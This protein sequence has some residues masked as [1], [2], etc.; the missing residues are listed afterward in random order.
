MYQYQYGGKKGLT[1]QLTEAS[2]LV[3]VRTKEPTN[4]K[5]LTLSE[6][7]K[8]LLPKM[9]PVV[10]FPEA[11]VTVF[12]CIDKASR[13][14][15]GGM[16]LRNQVRK[17]FNQEASIHFAGRVLKDAKSGEPVIYTENF[18]IK[19][20]D[21]ITKA[22]CKK[23]I[24]EERLRIKDQLKFASNAYFVC[25]E[26]GTGLKIFEYAQSLL[27]KGAVEYCHPEL[28]RQKKHRSIGPNQWHLK[29]VERNGTLI[30][31]HVNVE[32]A[33]TKTRGAGIT[34]AIL[35][36]G[37]DEFHEEFAGK[38][39]SPYDAIIDEQDGNPKRRGE[40][41]GTA[42]AG[43]AC[44]A[45]VNQASG[46]APEANLMPIRLGGLGSMAESKAFWWATDNG[47]DV[48]S[49]SWGP[50]DGPWWD[51]QDPQH[52]REFP[53]PDSTRLALEYALKNGR[54][55]K[56]C[57]IVWAAGNGNESCDLDGYASYPEVITVSASN[58][59]GVKSYYS[60]YG[61]AV[62]CCFPSND[63][64]SRFVPVPRPQPL[65][66]GIWTTDRLGGA[67][68]NPGGGTDGDV[69]GSYT[70]SFGGTSSS[71]PGVAGVAALMLAANN[72][73]T[74]AQVKAIIKNSCDKI[75]AEFGDYDANGHSPFYG[76][77]KI[78]ADTA[79]E[80]AI[81]ATD[82]EKVNYEVNGGAEFSKIGEVSIT[83]GQPTVKIPAKSRLLSMA[84]NVNPFCPTLSLEYKTVIN[85][86]E[87]SAW[88]KAESF[89]GT[90]DGRRKMIGFAIRLTGDLS[91][92]YEVLYQ[93]KLKG[94][95]DWVAEKNGKICGTTKKG[96]KAIEQIK[97]EIVKREM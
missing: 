6:N 70:N 12:K 77:G 17:E 44:A 8:R 24:K 73:L 29:P 47:A 41:H 37:V 10:S 15:G 21:S 93:A 86:K 39:V 43:V 63:V 94:K 56:G 81:M 68:Y 5:S 61:Q 19:F 7:S 53:L 26:K 45:G 82:T 18:F 35:D 90:A 32:A 80:N 33:W 31:Q 13:S 65:T 87:A 88:T 78:N 3:V 36:D 72:D 76:Y 30:D 38:I 74:S 84:L 9:M 89:S 58:D 96:G 52:F 48:I 27:K 57:V 79:V 50:M 22:E 1:L 75:D 92:Q 14:M 62:W 34:I 60:D 51:S 20:K 28:V 40:D 59:R 97:M 42:C 54:G 46:V 91:N 85:G 16:K 69:A 95:E 11:N 4:V 55:G 83:G 66:S 71:C 2:D 64:D 23:I 25:A 49:C 67:G